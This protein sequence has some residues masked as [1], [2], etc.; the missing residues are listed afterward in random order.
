MYGRPTF[1]EKDA[2]IVAERM[3]RLDTCEGPRVGDFVVFPDGETRRISCDWGRDCEP[4]IQTSE[5]GS[6]YLTEHGASFS[7]SL[8][9]TIPTA[10]LT[11]TGEKR[12]GDV[13]I[14]HHNF[15]GAGRGVHAS[16]LFRVYSASV[17]APEV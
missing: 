1:D 4:A 17:P 13:W 6:F 15:S 10:S 9:T 14:F 2:A 3:A 11:D 5:G 12:P 8:Y 7:G 16:P